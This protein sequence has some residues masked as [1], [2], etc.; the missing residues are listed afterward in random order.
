MSAYRVTLSFWGEQ[1]GCEF[2]LE[3]RQHES[4]EM[5]KE[6]ANLVLASTPDLSQAQITGVRIR[7]GSYSADGRVLSGYWLDMELVI[8][9]TTLDAARLQSRIEG[10]IAPT[11]VQL[12]APLITHCVTV[13]KC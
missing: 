11:L 6:L 3:H 7:R 1:N 9:T 10:V 12:I 8:H 4:E 5:A 13:M 2:D